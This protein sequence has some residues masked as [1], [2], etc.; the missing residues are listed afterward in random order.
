MP[1]VVINVGQLMLPTALFALQHQE[2]YLTIA[3]ASMSWI[4]LVINP[5]D[6]LSLDAT[7]RGRCVHIL[8]SG[9]MPANFDIDA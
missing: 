7:N 8:S 6:V 3:R 5:S 1:A 4:H 9:V 2:N